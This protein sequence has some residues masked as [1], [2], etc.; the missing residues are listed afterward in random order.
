MPWLHNIA[1]KNLNVRFLDE[2]ILERIREAADQDR[3][4][5]N[6]EIIWLIERGLACREDAE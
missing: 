6:S 3:R 2:E 4:S 5:V 1:M